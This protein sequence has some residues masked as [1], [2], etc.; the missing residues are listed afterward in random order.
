MS[1]GAQDSD[2]A[3]ELGNSIADASVLLG[4]LH[5]PFKPAHLTVKKTQFKTKEIFEGICEV[6]RPLKG[7]Y[8]LCTLATDRALPRGIIEL[9]STIHAVCDYI[10]CF[11]MHRC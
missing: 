11:I 9:A 2:E 3:Q 5:M 8:P 1:H 10:D 4:R 6:G 7:A